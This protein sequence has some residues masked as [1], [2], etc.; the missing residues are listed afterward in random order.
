INYS[1]KN[2]SV[3]GEDR[4]TTIIDGNQ[5]GSVVVFENGEGAETVLSGFT[6]TNGYSEFEGN[7][8]PY[9]TGGGI[10]FHSGSSPR[11]E[12]MIIT[13]NS[14][15]AGGGISCVSGSSPTL[16][17]VIISNNDSEGSGGGMMCSGSSP[18]LTHV[19]FTGNSAPWR[20]GGIGVSGAS[21]N[22]TF[23]NVTLIDNQSSTAGWPNSGGGGIAFWGGADC[24]I[25][26]SIFFGNNP[27]E[28]YL[29]T[30]EPPNS[31]NISYSNIQESWEGE[32]N[33]D[34]DPMFVDT[35]NGNFHLL[36][37]SQLINAGDPDSTDSDGS[38]ADIGAYPYLNSY[39]GP[40]WYI[41]ESGN[42]TT[43]TGASDDPFRS[44]QSGI[45]F[46]S[47]GDSVTV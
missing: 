46:S 17:N 29:A 33:I 20:G 31:I 18:T 15:N 16:N 45:N 7:Q 40:T 42:D 10:L 39:S 27:D 44:I 11:I 32:G 9:T 36:A 35:A 38:R 8:Y 34:V 3:I 43:A 47:G 1:G 2:I 5:N 22:P 26:N 19:L 25:S 23:T 30:D 21:S 12:N 6:L 13:N 4:E 41:S 37:S 14:G 24:S 28:I